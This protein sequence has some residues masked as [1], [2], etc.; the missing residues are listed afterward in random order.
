MNNNKNRTAKE[1]SR[2]IIGSLKQS[3]AYSKG[4][5]VPGLKKKIVVSVKLPIYKSVEIKKVRRKHKLTQNALAVT[6]GVSKKTVEAWESNRN[7]PYGPA[8]RVLYLL[9]KKPDLMKIL[10]KG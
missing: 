9:D 2:G 8:Q 4:E 7:I 10:T 5:N 3:L 6:L 1:I